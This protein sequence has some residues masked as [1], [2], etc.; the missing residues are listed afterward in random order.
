MLGNKTVYSRWS[1][2][3]FIDCCQDVWNTTFEKMWENLGIIVALLIFHNQCCVKGNSFLQRLCTDDTWQNFQFTF[4]NREDVYL[5]SENILPN[6]EQIYSK[7]KY[8]TTYNLVRLLLIYKSHMIL[9]VNIYCRI[10][11]T[12]IL[13]Y[14]DQEKKYLTII[15][16]H[17]WRV[18]IL[19]CKHFIIFFIITWPL[20]LLLSDFHIH[21]R[22]H[23][24][25]VDIYTK[26]NNKE[27]E[28]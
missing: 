22:L 5:K 17:Q 9:F 4:L 12:L 23:T 19:K 7:Y 18:Y 21:T 8:I 11:E 14:Y 15:E 1:I 6:L 16:L 26:Y 20:L 25:T 3:F 28:Y 27:L 2:S 13:F 24:V 10:C